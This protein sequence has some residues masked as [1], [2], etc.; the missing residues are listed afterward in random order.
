MTR[1]PPDS[2]DGRHYGPTPVR[3]DTDPPH[4]FFAS[5]DVER[6]RTYAET[7][8]QLF[9][10]ARAER[11]RQVSADSHQNDF[12]GKI[13]SLKTDRHR[14]VP[15]CCTVKCFK[16]KYDKAFVSVC[17]IPPALRVMLWHPGG[18]P[19]QIPQ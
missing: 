11:V 12:F 15:S 3:I 6:A 10:V 17:V 1:A 19:C 5:Q 18:Q 8:H 9:D 2:P 13:G 7:F 16:E 4:H 14:H